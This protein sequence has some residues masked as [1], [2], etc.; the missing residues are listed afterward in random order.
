MAIS[1]LF[2]FNNLLVFFCA[3]EI[4]DINTRMV[5]KIFFEFFIRFSD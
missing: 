5:N 2:S 3:K 1:A 4:C